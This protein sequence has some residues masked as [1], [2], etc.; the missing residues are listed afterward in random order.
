[1]LQINNDPMR[2][3]TNVQIKTKVPTVG[4]TISDDEIK[5]VQVGNDQEKAQSERNSH[6]KYRGGSMNHQGQ[7]NKS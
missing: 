2:K 4:R 7:T 3:G 5:K 6:S 1:M